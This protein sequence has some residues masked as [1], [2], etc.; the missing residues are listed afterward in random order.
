[1]SRF[2]VHLA[3]TPEDCAGLLEAAEE[4]D[5][6]LVD[7][8]T[9]AEKRIKAP[10][11]YVADKVW[12]PIHRCLTEDRTPNGGLDGDSGEY[13]L[14]MVILGGEP[15]H[16]DWSETFWLVEAEDVPAV[17][18]ALHELEEAWLRKRFFALPDDQFHALSEDEFGWVWDELGELRRFFTL[19]AG[20]GRAVLCTISH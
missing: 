2:A 12:E 9:E 3:L 4:G 6:A 10:F 8:L 20:H 19:A 18:S 16:E 5:D 15:L 14:N 11:L 13:P 17:A 7:W 1:M